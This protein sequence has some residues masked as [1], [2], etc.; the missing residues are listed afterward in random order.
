MAAESEKAL[1]RTEDPQRQWHGPR[2]GGPKGLGPGKP[3][4]A[5]P[6]KGQ[7]PAKIQGPALAVLARIVGPKPLAERRSP[8]PNRGGP[9]PPSTG[10]PVRHYVGGDPLWRAGARPPWL[11]LGGRDKAPPPTEGGV[12]PL[13]S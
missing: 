6:Q 5:L 9:T 8:R 13:Q 1:F 2:L 7:E 4:K 3:W 10:N 11:K 12:F